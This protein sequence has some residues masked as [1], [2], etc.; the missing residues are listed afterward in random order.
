MDIQKELMDWAKTVVNKY[1]PVARTENSSY[2]TQ[3]NLKI[4]KR[5]PQVLILGINPGS[6]GNYKEI[7]PDTFLGG[8]QFF[9][10]D[11][12]WHIWNGLKKIFRAGGIE[13]LLENEEDFVFSNIYHFD[14]PKADQL[15]TKI[16]NDN[17]YIELTKKLIQK[18]TPTMVIC[19]GKDDCMLKLIKSPKTLIDDGE[20]LYGEINSIPIYGIPHTSKYYTNEESTMLGEILSSLYKKE[21]LPEKS[22]LSN[23]F[24][25]VI[26]AFKDRKEQIRPDNILN[27]MIEDSFKRYVRKDTID[28]KWYRISP[29]FRVQVTSVGGGEVIIRDDKYTNGTNYLQNP[30]NNQDVIIQYLKEKGYKLNSDGAR[31][32]SLGHKPFRKYET[33][34]DGPQH[35]VLSILKDIDE[36][37]SELEEI[38]NKEEM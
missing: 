9:S 28:N 7:N 13:K 3:S 27:S 31:K 17:D 35:V 10:H 33:W 18:L 4:I 2:Y 29:N 34:K 25:D 22:E 23:R 8:N 15:L 36:L 38:Y 14:T 6:S 24:K 19:L 16:K 12:N 30:I 5:S 11:V 21:V 1:D 26:K 20:L 37:G 32:T